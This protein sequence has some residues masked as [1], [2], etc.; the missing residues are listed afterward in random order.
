[1]QSPAA[2]FAFE[3]PLQPGIPTPHARDKKL[4]TAKYAGG[5]IESDGTATLTDCTFVGNSAELGGGLVDYGTGAMTLV[6]AT[7]ADN[8]STQVGY[9]AEVIDDGRQVTLKPNQNGRRAARPRIAR[10]RPACE[11]RP[12]GPNIAARSGPR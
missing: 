8:T 6:N 4:K 10:T 5:A 7:V 2:S 12:I 9:A 11:A 3:K 1:M